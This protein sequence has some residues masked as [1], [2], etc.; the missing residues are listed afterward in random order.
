[1][2]WATE[3]LVKMCKPNIKM[4]KPIIKNLLDLVIFKLRSLDN[5]WNFCVNGHVVA[6]KMN[7]IVYLE[8]IYQ[9]LFPFWPPL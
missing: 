6:F 5:L 4:Y 1:M 8:S 9:N 7:L 3:I 2:F